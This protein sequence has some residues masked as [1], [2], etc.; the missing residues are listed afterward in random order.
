MHDRSHLSA[1][2]WK[3]RPWLEALELSGLFSWKCIIIV[4][5]ALYALFLLFSQKLTKFN[6]IEDKCIRQETLKAM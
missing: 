2:L 3:Q 4:V 5:I 1:D 6:G